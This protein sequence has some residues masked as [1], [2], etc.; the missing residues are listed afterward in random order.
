METKKEQLNNKK[1]KVNHEGK[2]ESQ[3]CDHPQLRH[4]Q[5]TSKVPYIFN[6]L[7]TF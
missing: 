3:Y 6:N 1:T 7:L 5:E 2:E 4:I